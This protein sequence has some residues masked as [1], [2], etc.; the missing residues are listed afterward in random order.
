MSIVAQAL[1]EI[2]RTEAAAQKLLDTAKERPRTNGN[3]GSTDTSWPE[4]T[5]L[6]SN[7]PPV[8]KF[9]S[10]LLPSVL[11]VRAQEIAKTTQAPIDFV[12]VGFLVAA[13]SLVA[14]HIAIR[15][16]A[17]DNWTVVPN[18]W[19]LIVGRPSAKKSPALKAALV[20]LDRL[21]DKAGEKHEA[22]LQEFQY[23]QQLHSHQV[24]ASHSGIQKLLKSSKDED[25]TEA[26]DRI[27]EMTEDEPQ[28]PSSKR[29]IAND[30]TVEK[31]GELLR[32][33]PSVLVCRDELQGFFAGL[34]RHGQES[35]RSFYLE[36]WDGDK[37]FKV[38][39]IS[40]GSIRIPR[41]CVSVLGGIQPGPMGSLMREIQRNSRSNDGLLQRFQ[42][43]V[44][45]DLSNRFELIDNE[46]D[47]EIWRQTTELFEGLASL[48]P[49]CRAANTDGDGIP[50]LR[51][52]I[53][54]QKIFSAWLL[55]H[56]NRL[57]SDELPECLEAHLGKYPS[58]V[59]SIALI[60]HLAEGKE[61]PV[62]FDA[63]TKAIAWAKYLETHA[64]RLYAPLTGADFVSARAL[65]RKLKSKGLPAT[66]KLRDVYRN[67]WAN[68][69]T[70]DEARVATEI[71]EDYDWI[72]SQAQATTA[73]G[74]RPTTVFTT[75]PLIWEVSE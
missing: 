28:E 71:L 5:P 30:T 37:P 11:S 70:L 44:W 2:D 25:K 39:R 20:P 14:R 63:I 43:A 64:K 50:Y 12:A 6:P 27:R 54:A 41:V 75:N 16:K 52:D 36:A 15:P 33:N 68:L 49:A 67:G 53:E 62:G 40:R 24:K 51:F 34:E 26:G 57:R 56:E 66:F 1:R 18:L 42:I 47:K 61:G 21:E 7:L 9:E 58:L 59:P 8:L 38:D 72:H 10:E 69:S 46:P 74:G 17:S 65:A 45:P 73:A 48:D 60:L 3:D 23:R 55:D 32:D 29:Y 19:G 22:A 31:L 13:S 4:P 35:A